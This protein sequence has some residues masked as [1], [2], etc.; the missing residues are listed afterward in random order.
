MKIM[1]KL[2]LL[3]IGIVLV[4]TISVLGVG[5]PII[6]DILY[7]SEEQVL[8]LELSNASKTILQRLNRSGARAAAETAAEM[9]HLLQQ[10]KGLK[11]AQLS[12][13]EAPDNRVVYHADL[14]AGDRAS[15]DFIDQMFRRE[16]G[17]IEYEFKQVARYA[18]F[19]TVTPV[20]WL[21]GLSISKQEMLE[22]R[23]D[24]LLAIGV[25]TFVILAL[26]ALVIRLFGQRLLRR[27]GAA[28]DCVKRI[29]Q[30][31]LAA[32]ISLGTVAD[33]IGELQQGI[34][35]MSARI[36]QRTIEQQQAEQARRAS[37]ARIRR[38]V[39]SNII[40]IFFFDLHG[41]ISEA[42]DAFLRMIGYDRDD[43]RSGEIQWTDLTPP[44]YRALDEQ[45]T[46][47]V[48][49]T[50]ACTPYEK[51]YIRKDGS[52]IPVLIGAVLFEDSQEQGVAFVLDLTERRQAEVERAARKSAEAANQ[53]KSAFLANMSHELRTPLN[54][55][56]GYAQILLRDKTLSER[57]ITGLTVIQKSGE[58]LLTLIN[59]IL[60]FAKIEAGK[61]ELYLTD[62]ELHGF[63]RVIAEMVEVKATQKDLDFKCDF[64]PDLPA[65]VRADEKRLRQVLLNLLSN[66]VK[67]TDRGSVRLGVRLAA[68]GRFRFEVQDSGIGIGADQLEVIFKPFEQ[69]GDLQRRV[70]GTGLGLAISRQFLKLMGSD[71]QVQSR[72]GQGSTFW[73]EVDLQV[74]ASKAL[75]SRAPG[76]IGYAGARK[77]ILVV[78]DVAD[79]RAVALDMLRQLGFEM[80]GAAS[81]AD[82]LEKAQ[83]LQPD[84]ILMDLVMPG[85]DGMEATRRLRELPTFKDVP[86]IALSA[87]ASDDDQKK[88]LL[89]GANAF[90]AKPVE[91]D[92]LMTQIA[93]LLHLRLSY[94]PLQAAPV[95]GDKEAGP[96]IAP[97]VHEIED[98]YRL[99]RLGNMQ[100]I[101][102]WASRQEALDERYRP[103]ANQLRVLAKGYQS[104]A[105]L[106]LA[107]RHLN[108]KEAR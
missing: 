38:L 30:G 17:T 62:I 58:H 35:V 92:S 74:I 41:G 21:F 72:V 49:S 44:E 84:L 89:S 86:I 37:E 68:P 105:I 97:P 47:E 22:Q 16:D 34:N 13:V 79:N 91:C 50:G 100:S 52:R 43:L 53:A 85:M 24:F 6:N 96:L 10:K 87:S 88:S 11:T 64:A 33:E 69:A 60:D 76:V 102:H 70:G 12:V 57:E 9:Q 5:T 93:Q 66:A 36:Q 3:S 99:A 101:L 27:I 107:K 48:R 77:R 82:G 1:T 40:G 94:D 65:W 108:S 31:E 54:G 14:A 7:K 8:R 20:N 106:N 98:L 104:K 26:N 55:I 63:L 71:V 46:V 4:M 61:L 25:I 32:R 95:S 29:E 90:V 42:S 103:F 23:A 19:T 28:Q 2:N 75:V 83:A 67:F 18:V 80:I 51:E 59:D 15:F 56:L 78:D 45:K 81:G 39:E 73:F